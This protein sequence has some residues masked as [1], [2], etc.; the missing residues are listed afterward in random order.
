M[1]RFARIVHGCTGSL[2]ETTE[3]DESRGTALSVVIRD[4]QQAPLARHSD[5]ATDT[6][7][8]TARWHLMAEAEVQFL[9]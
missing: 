2:T 5:S 6:G 9:N 7:G 8:R 4:P 3:S 1:A